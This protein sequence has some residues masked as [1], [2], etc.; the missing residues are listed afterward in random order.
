MQG[1]CK[2]HMVNIELEEERKLRRKAQLL[3]DIPDPEEDEEGFLELS[4]EDEEE[5][6]IDINDPEAPLKL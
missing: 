3:E 2:I 1:L 4:L 5:E 6:T